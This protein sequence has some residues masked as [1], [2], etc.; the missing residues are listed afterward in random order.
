MI[1]RL[2]GLLML[3]VAL[4]P[5]AALIV[6]VIAGAQVINR[7]ETVVET[8][9]ENLNERID[10]INT[11]IA[12]ASTNFEIVG[13]VASAVAGVANSAVNA[14]RD[15]LSGIANIRIGPIPM[16]GI[17]PDIP[18]FN[19]RIPGLSQ[20]AQF[21]ENAFASLNQLAQAIAGLGVVQEI[22]AEIAAIVAETTSLIDDILDIFAPFVS[23]FIFVIIGG[24]AWL[25]AWYITFVYDY[26]VRG[27]A[28][29]RGKRP[30]IAFTPENQPAAAA[31]SP[32]PARDD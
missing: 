11:K 17:V 25:V 32:A 5:V 20:I 26:L 15:T 30:Q 27:W 22:P 6:I 23:A 3:F 12:E 21:L 2:M 1:R 29:L 28:L 19:F 8:R 4:F 14:I 24:V 18:A 31:S 10:T 13:N 7:A 16:P 9:L